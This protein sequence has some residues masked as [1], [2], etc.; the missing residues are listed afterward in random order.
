MDVRQHLRSALAAAL[1]GA[2]IDMP[3]EQIAIER[4]ANPSHGDWSSNV[5]LATAKRAGRNPR[6][7]AQ[8]L[9]D[10]LNAEPPRHVTA[11]EVAGAG[12]VNFRLAPTW[13][14]EVLVGITEAGAE[15]FAR[16]AIGT[17][18]SV[19]IEYVSAN[20]TG[21]LHAGHGRWAA[22]GDSLARLFERCGFEVTREFYVN[23]RG[24]QMSLFGAS[25]AARR[26]GQDPPEGGYF[27][28]YV[29]EWAQEMPDTAD[30]VDWGSQR[31]HLDQVEVLASMNAE[32]DHWASE[33][34][35]AQSGAVEATLAVLTEGGHVYE[36]E[37]ATWLRT[38]EFD[39]NQDRVLIKSDGQP[40]Y[41]LPDIAYHQQKYSRGDLLIDILGADHHGYVKRMS[42]AMQ[43]LGHSADSYEVLIGQHVTLV[44]DGEEVRL[45]K[46]AGTMVEARELVELVGADVARLTFLLQSIDTTQTIDVDLVVAESSENPVYYVQY[47]NARVHSLARRAE[48]RDISLSPLADV[49]L[50]VLTH[51]R[52]LTL[53]RV[54]SELPEVVERAMQARAPHQV[55]TWA[56]ECAAALHGFWHDCPILRDDLDEQVRQGR[57]WLVEA[58]RIGL[59]VS[60]DLLGV[61]APESM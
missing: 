51:Q 59:G 10:A 46:R 54:L 53:L 20:P 38:S 36:S 19:D 5:A 6:E 23:D 42:A 52:E 48:E 1:F 27:G 31:A 37:G 2:E 35:L 7:L 17:G 41:F 22:Y 57:M 49:D 34:R 12:F 39:D 9:A 13:L 47:A 32:F 25:L 28:E 40:T 3:R 56:R 18:S 24:E 15:D 60:L 33:N 50:S 30:P 44:R 21:P 16:S 11:V 8:E 26:T 4:P 14:H 58:T 43:M 55:T 29:T 45:S 61:S